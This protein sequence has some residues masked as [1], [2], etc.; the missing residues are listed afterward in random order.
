MAA[1][2]PWIGLAVSAAGTAASAY[3]SSKANSA[4]QAAQK[5]VQGIADTQ[6]G[7]T[8][9]AFGSGLPMLNQAGSY[10]STL[11][12][13]N[14]TAMSAA[15]AGPRAAITD[16]YRGAELGLKRAGVTGGVRDQ[17]LAELSRDR[18]AKVAGLTT[19]VQPAAAQGLSGIGANLLGVSQ[20]F[21][22]NAGGLYGS[23]MQNTTQNA[24]YQ[25]GQ[26]ASAGSSFGSLLF[27]L[28][29]SYKPKS[30]DQPMM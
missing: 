24:M 22:S 20:G 2:I 19:G 29:K 10:W 23:L 17:S 3:S 8:K 28:L 13:G 15:T 12:G 6:L 27:D 9:Q 18:A 16:Q 1:A 30:T 7:M 14:R 25:S 26:A 4:M 5:G 11:L 21:G